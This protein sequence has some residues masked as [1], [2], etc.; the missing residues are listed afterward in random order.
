[1]IDLKNI[2]FD[3]RFAIYREVF[4]SEPIRVDVYKGELM[5]LEFKRIP[6]IDRGILDFTTFEVNEDKEAS[7]GSIQLYFPKY[8]F[9]G[10]LFWENSFK[11]FGV[12]QITPRCLDLITQKYFDAFDP[13]SLNEF[14]DLHMKRLKK[15]NIQYPS[16][17]YRFY[18][19]AKTLYKDYLTF[20]HVKDLCHAMVC[21][22]DINY[23]TDEFEHEMTLKYSG[24][25][26][27]FQYNLA[28]IGDAQ[29]KIGMLVQES[30]TY[31]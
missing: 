31:I 10:K 19:N 16:S 7:A 18:A 2:P 30:L 27:N 23:I 4:Y 3:D 29:H 25:I 9:S 20:E 22:R 28:E 15:M 1:M 17:K 26:K 24:Y 6:P 14:A 5:D 8:F 12:T 11:N 13:S 21:I